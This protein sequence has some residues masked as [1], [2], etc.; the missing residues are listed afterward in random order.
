MV[1][2]SVRN[3]KDT[4]YKGLKKQ[5]QEHG[6]SMEEEARQLIYRG[7]AKSESI[8]EVFTRHF[9]PKNGVELGPILEEIRKEDR[10]LEKHPVSFDP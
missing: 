5:A 8:A 7:L 1:N 10:K 9:G 2:I 3:L 6:V 4:A